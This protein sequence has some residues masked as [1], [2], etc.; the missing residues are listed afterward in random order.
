M[1]YEVSFTLDKVPHC[2]TCKGELMYTEGFKRNPRT[3][4]A[5]RK[6]R[7]GTGH[8]FYGSL[9]DDLK[10]VLKP[11]RPTPGQDLA[12]GRGGTTTVIPRSGGR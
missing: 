1:K 10:E 5:H 2:P 9:R 12:E 3:N 11:Y 7:C 8:T 4:V 6:Y